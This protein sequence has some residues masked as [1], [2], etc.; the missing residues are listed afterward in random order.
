MTTVFVVG[1]R[2][3]VRAAA[4][5][6]LI[7]VGSGQTW[8]RPN[9]TNGTFGLT[10]TTIGPGNGSQYYSVCAFTVSQTANY[11][12]TSSNPTGLLVDG[13]FY[14]YTGSFNAASPVS[15]SFTIGN[16]DVVAGSQR[17][18]VIASV[19]LTVGT[20]YY[21]VTTSFSPGATGSLNVRF[22]EPTSGTVTVLNNVLYTAAANGTISGITAQYMFDGENGTPVTAVPNTG[23]HFTGWSDGALAETRSETN[24]T[25]DISLT[26]NFAINTYG[27]T[28]TAGANG[29]I[30][31]ITPQTVNHGSNGTLV[32]AVPDTG[33]HLTSW[34]DGVLTAAR[35]DTNITAEQGYTA[36]FAINQ[37]ALTYTAGANGTVTGGASQSVDH[38]NDAAAVTAVP[39]TGYHFTGWSD[40][41]L[42]AARTD[43]IVTSDLSVTANFA[44]N[45]YTLAYAAGPNGTLTGIAS[46]AVN[47]GSDG[48]AVTAVPATGYHFTGWSD[49][50]LTAART[51]MSVK[52]NLSV[53]ANFAIN[54]YTVVFQNWDGSVLS[55][56]NVVYGTDAIAPA[57]PIR[58]GYTFTSWSLPFTGVTGNIITVAGYSQN[59]APTATPTPVT[60]VLGANTTTAAPAATATPATGVLSAAKTGETDNQNTILAALI[61]LA[62]F[63]AVGT[64]FVLRWKKPQD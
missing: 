34:S 15:P 23:Y 25:S 20:I 52:A 9:P 41:V 40:G 35:T 7:T 48:T 11:S 58:S 59:P 53:T 19:P 12:I 24:V 63:G 32:T 31:G 3:P 22:N 64:V 10:F 18:P 14:L 60:D 54:S 38:G 50:V 26:A 17:N 29:S 28:Y 27:L 4:T 56:Q 16:D 8:T 44:I 61:L 47:Y 57:N 46:Q 6:V 36:N 1:N 55:E 13:M 62:A 51:D 37:Y 33:Y 5:D 43:M 39:D 30:S 49:G 45:S 42:T 2:E 21:L